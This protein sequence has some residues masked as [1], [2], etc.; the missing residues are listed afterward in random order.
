MSSSHRSS[1]SKS[2]KGSSSP[3]S[4]RSSSKHS[5][6]SSSSKSKPSSSS[7]SHS[8][9]KDRD[10]DRDKDGSGH[11]DKDRDR[12]STSKQ[13]PSPS[14]LTTPPQSPTIANVPLSSSPSSSHVSKQAPP[15]HLKQTQIYGKFLS[16][17]FLSSSLPSLS[18][19]LLS[20]CIIAQGE[21]DEQEEEEDD[22]EE[23]YDT[24][25]DTPF[26]CNQDT[27]ESS[28]AA[29]LSLE[30]FYKSLFTR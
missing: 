28:M 17:N 20:Y 7:S 30:Q 5:S 4:E 19:S 6:S 12:E 15:S 9:S 14:P 13:H 18:P 8:S 11:R 24:E 16:Q 1:S 29:K 22:D 25:D 3:R 10:R 2:S 23:Y 27:L 21:Q 26:T